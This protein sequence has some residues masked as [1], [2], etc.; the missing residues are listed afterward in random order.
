VGTSEWNDKSGGKK[1]IYHFLDE[2]T[3]LIGIVNVLNTTKDFLYVITES[4]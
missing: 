3:P 4:F 1:W 2:E